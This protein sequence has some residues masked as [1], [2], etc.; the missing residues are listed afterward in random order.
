MLAPTAETVHAFY[1]FLVG[2]RNT[3]G[4][5]LI[6][7]LRDIRCVL[8]TNGQFLAPAEQTIFLPR[9]DASVPDNI[10]VPIAALPDVVG[11][12]GLLTDLGVKDFEWR[13][14]IREYLV[15]I[16]ENPSAD[17]GSARGQW[18]AFAPT[19]LFGAQAARKLERYSEGCSF[20]YERQ[21]A[22]KRPCAGRIRCTSVATGRAP[23]G[24]N[25]STVRFGEPEFLNAEIPLDS[26]DR[27]TE[28][29]S[30]GCLASSIIRAWMGRPAIMHLPE[31]AIPTPTQ[32]SRSGL[33]PSATT[34]AAVLKST[35]QVKSSPCKLKLNRLVG[36]ASGNGRS[37]PTLSTVE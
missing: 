29:N 3:H 21:T 17:P 2:W 18:K 9:R 23:R 16:L 15:K 8:T 32:S 14:L 36:P 12:Q 5:S 13:D 20:Q 7:E 24:W 22:P 10:P 27:R 33:L 26:D 34:R 6:D 37:A 31:R 1:S 19:N 11:L 28:S 35:T 30:I 4:L 25:R